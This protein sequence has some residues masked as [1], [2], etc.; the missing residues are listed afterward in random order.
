MTVNKHLIR[1][2]LLGTLA[3]VVVGLIGLV[4]EYESF[5]EKHYGKS[6]S[7]MDEVVR[8]SQN[9]FKTG[10]FESVR[11]LGHVGAFLFFLLKDDAADG[12]LIGSILLAP[13]AVYT[14]DVVAASRRKR[15][16]GAV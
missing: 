5:V 7:Q 10:T 13:F 16:Q 14:F 15:E 11:V 12:I 3:G 6:I 4:L 9:Q 8:D 2:Y 1:R